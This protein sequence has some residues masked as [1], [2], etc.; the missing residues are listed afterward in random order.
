MSRAYVTGENENPRGMTGS[1][2]YYVADTETTCSDRKCNKKCNWPT[3]SKDWRMFATK[4][5]RDRTAEGL[6]LV[7]H[8]VTKENQS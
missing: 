5:A 2:D 8:T 3:C 7:G 1:K 4:D 6:K